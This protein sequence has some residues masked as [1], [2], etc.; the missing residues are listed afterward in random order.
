MDGG[1]FILRMKETGGDEKDFLKEV[2]E[3]CKGVEGNF[4]QVMKE[5]NE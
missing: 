2:K 5:T 3:K 1:N 4:L